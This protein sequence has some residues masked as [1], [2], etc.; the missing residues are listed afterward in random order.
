ML[1]G[2][3]YGQD[4]FKHSIAVGLLSKNILEKYF[5]EN[6]FKNILKIYKIDEDDRVF[7]Y[8]FLKNVLFNIGVYHDIG[9]VDPN[10]QLF[11]QQVSKDDIETFDVQIDATKEKKDFDINTYPLHHEISWSLISTLAISN[12]RYKSYHQNLIEYVIYWHHAKVLRSKNPFLKAKDILQCKDLDLSSIIKSFKTFNEKVENYLENNKIGLENLYYFDEDNKPIDVIEACKE[13]SIPDFQ[14]IKFLQSNDIQTERE[15]F[16]KNS[17][18]YLFRSIVVSADRI[19]SELSPDLLNEIFE[20]KDYESLILGKLVKEENASIEEGITLMLESFSNKYG[21]SARSHKQELVAEQ[22]AKIDDVAVLSGPAGVGKTKIMLDWVNRKN[23]KSK[24][25][26]ITPKTSI[27]YSLYKE[28][29]TEYLPTN[30]IEIITG[31]MKERSVNG[32]IKELDDNDVFNSDFNITTIDQLLS[33]MMS[34]KKIDVFLEVL[35]STII[36]DEFH[37]FLDTPGIVMLFIQFIALKRISINNDCLLVSATPNPYLVNRK[38]NIPKENTVK[39]E[40][41]NETLYDIKVQNFEDKKS[42]SEVDNDMYHAKKMGQIVLFNSATKAQIS[43]V[44]SMKEKEE[45]TL[46]YHSKF[47]K[48][49]RATIF[50][51][52]M[53][54]FGKQNKTKRNV[55]RTGPILQASI[56]ISTHSMLTE[57]SSIDNIFQR[58]GRVVRWGE[59][60]NGE[61]AIYIPTNLDDKTTL[62]RKGLENVGSFNNAKAFADFISEKLKDKK[63]WTLNELYP[64]YDEFFSKEDTLKAYDEDWKNITEKSKAVFAQGFEPIKMIFKKKKTKDKKSK[65]LAKKSLR[66]KSMFALACTLEYEN[67]QE[68]IIEPEKDF[69]KSLFSIEKNI[70][71]GEENKNNILEDNRLQIDNSFNDSPY[72]YEIRMNLKEKNNIA[73]KSGIAKIPVFMFLDFARDEKTPLI[74]SFKKSLKGSKMDKEEEK[75]NV[76]YEKINLGIMDYSLF[77]KI[78]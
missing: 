28:I 63:T 7:N 17:I 72:L 18:Y 62:L 68:K 46:V 1:L 76:K 64:L 49:D 10:F 61:Y 45:N 73:Q 57:I 66:G 47:F 39:I 71:R 38:L 2:N 54:E 31:D 67:N 29:S 34:H 78:K 44:K 77:N 51:R 12:K 9:K 36:F 37:E 4:L 5:P 41:F 60:K 59:N 42:N 43:A 21:N 22:L 14:S 27:C 70:F 30:T 56:D 35:N 48:N 74:L 40:S 75:F 58:L 13:N 55:L 19:I 52:I 50:S 32:I 8:N 23:K 3:S 6:L 53:N 26:I 25:F 11:L 16:V 15:E 20:E 33:L 24:V 69:S 65:T